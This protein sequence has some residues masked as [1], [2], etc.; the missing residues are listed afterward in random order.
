M[1]SQWIRKLGLKPH[2]EGGY[3]QETYRCREKI[4]GKRRSFATAIYYLLEEGQFSAFHRLKSDEIWYFHAGGPLKIFLLDGSSKAHVIELGRSRFQAVIPKG[5]WFAA[6]PGS[7]SPFSLV[8]C[9]VSP[10][11]DFSD[12]ELG[13]RRELVARFPRHRQLIE[14]FTHVVADC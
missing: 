1:S 12:F 8:S 7:R 2:P 11:F 9:S 10:G 13:R 6:C 14:R 3:F 5:V 4:P